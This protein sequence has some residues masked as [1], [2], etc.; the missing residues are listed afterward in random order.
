[1]TND[2][3]G[4]TTGCPFPPAASAEATRTAVV[5]RRGGVPAHVG[6]PA[7]VAERIG[8]GWRGVRISLDGGPE[9]VGSWVVRRGRRHGLAE[10]V[11]FVIDEAPE[12]W[13][14]LA[15]QERGYEESSVR[16][17][18]GSLDDVLWLYVIDVQEGTVTPFSVHDDRWLAPQPVH[19]ADA[20][21]FD[22]WSPPRLEL[23][24]RSPGV[25]ARW[26]GQVAWVCE[27]TGRRV[28]QLGAM[29]REALERSV[30][31]HW[32]RRPPPAVASFAAGPGANSMTRI[33]VGPTVLQIPDVL[34][35]DDYGSVIAY[36][37]DERWLSP[38]LSSARTWGDHVE[39]GEMLAH[40][41]AR[42]AFGD[43]HGVEL[44]EGRSHLTT[45]VTR[46]V[47][48]APDPH[49]PTEMDILEAL[50]VDPKARLGGFAHARV[51]SRH[52]KAWSAVLASWFGAGAAPRGRRWRVVETGAD[53][54]D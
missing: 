35:P 44:H 37:P 19:G 54:P 13:V 39:I 21:W 26:R 17:A 8:D 51:D 31:R 7:I 41:A 30:E 53:E 2:V 11:R 12:G 52:A 50:Q 25:P 46:R 14:S 3:D 10:V 34:A 29:V 5:T 27:Q 32:L 23:P 40:T 16:D 36:A 4:A 15:G 6:T 38:E 18:S 33:R 20:D 47:V 9:G 43:D 22:G 1:M 49:D 28:E 48:D 42:A 45:Y 24:V